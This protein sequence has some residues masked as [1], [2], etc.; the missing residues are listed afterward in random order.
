MQF[1]IA[2]CSAVQSNAMQSSVA[3]YSAV[4]SLDT[5][6]LGFHILGG[7]V[8]AEDGK[9]CVVQCSTVQYGAVQY[10]SAI[11]QCSTTVQYYIYVLD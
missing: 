6:S 3:Q 9:W 5:V 1:S 8:W 4:Q 10:Y 2:P 7:R 11:L